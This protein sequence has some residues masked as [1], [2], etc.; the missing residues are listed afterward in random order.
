VVTNDDAPVV[1]SVVGGP[2][3][4]GATS[5]LLTVHGVGFRDATEVSFSRS[6]LKVVAGSLHVVDDGSLT[7][8]VAAASTMATG[9]IVVRVAIPDAAAGSCADC[10]SVVGRP[11]VASTSLDALG[12]GASHQTVTVSGSGF[13]DGAAVTVAGAVVHSTTF[14]S[15]HQLQVSF[16][17]PATRSPGVALVKVTNPDGGTSTCR[18]CASFV[19]GPHL[20]SAPGIAGRRSLSQTVHLSG[21]GFADGLTL[22]GPAGV[23][24]TDLVV[25]P[26]GITATMTV[27]STTRVAAGQKITV[28]N[29]AS[30]GW[31]ASTA[32]PLTVCTKYATSCG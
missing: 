16:S 32:T 17:V 3:P 26:T 14:V 27:A 15:A 6:G 1:S 10:L 24:F 19:A 8:R 23:S 30:A 22:S 20:D 11:V 7:V 4:Q 21:S 12:A 29:P 5:Q 9:P 31:G 28:T 13:V 2:V 25:S 18:T